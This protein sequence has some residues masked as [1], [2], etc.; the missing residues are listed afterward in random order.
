MTDVKI[1]LT[2]WQAERAENYR[3]NTPLPPRKF[4]DIPEVLSPAGNFEKLKAAVLYGADAV[5]LAA[6]QFGLRAFAGNFS[7]EELAAAV[8]YA[9]RHGVRVYVTINI[10][11]HPSDLPALPPIVEYVDRCGADGVIVSDPGIFRLVREYAPRMEIHISTQASVTN[12]EACQFWYEAGARRIILAR[13][14]SLKDIKA[15]RRDIP[16]NMTLEG[17]VHG[18][19]CMA[20]SG[21]CLLSN[22]ATGRDA[23]RG[24]CA[25]PCRWSYH[26]TETGRLKDAEDGTGEPYTWAVEQDETGSFLFS[27]RDICMIEHIPDLVEAGINSFKIEGRMKGAYYVAVVTKVYREA[28]DTWVREGTNMKVRPEWLDELTAMVHRDYD[29]GF[30]FHHPLEEAKIAQ[31]RARNIQATVVAIALETVGDRLRCEQRNKLMVG[32]EVEIVTPHGKNFSL[33]V[34]DLFDE[35]GEHVMSCPHPQQIFE[36]TL[37]PGQVVEPGS[38]IRRRGKKHGEV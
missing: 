7:K 32:E 16:E 5:Y 20:W 26:V 25:Q 4:D 19:M 23:N 1:Q 9:H 11:A 28:V 34:T 35:N 2:P 8:N 30:Y 29:T 14:L 15:I 10:L 33:E 17:F 31:S 18:A 13:E 24:A 38:F 36:M 21:R 37:P 27:S 22:I 12:Q 6:H 3:P